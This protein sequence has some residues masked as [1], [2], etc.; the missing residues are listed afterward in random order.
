MSDVEASQ[1]ETELE[2]YEQKLQ[3]NKMKLFNKKHKDIELIL[4]KIENL[5]FPILNKKYPKIDAQEIINCDK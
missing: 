3:Y 1:A 2:I 5:K 4:K